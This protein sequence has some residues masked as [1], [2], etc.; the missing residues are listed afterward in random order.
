MSKSV[1][2]RYHTSNDDH[3]QNFFP[4][5]LEYFLLG[6][7]PNDSG[8]FLLLPAFAAVVVETVVVEP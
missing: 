4:L 2:L 7:P 1:Y 3:Y 8:S 6:F 5:P